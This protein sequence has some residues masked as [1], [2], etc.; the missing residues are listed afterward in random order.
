[1]PE[2]PYLILLDA[3][4][5]RLPGVEPARLV[6]AQCL[7]MN[8]RRIDFFV[9]RDASDR[10]EDRIVLR[11]DVVQLPAPA[12]EEVCRQLLHANNLWAGTHGAT[13]ALR[14]D[15]TVMLGISARIASLDGAGLAHMLNSLYRE[16]GR[17]VEKLTHTDDALAMFLEM[18]V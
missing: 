4:A 14:G 8:N 12:S 18:R 1:M 17:W 3:L 15:D 11:C 9:Q 16:A 10:G 13:L 6:Q 7:Q 2:D 5:R